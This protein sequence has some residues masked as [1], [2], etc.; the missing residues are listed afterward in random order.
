[1]ITDDTFANNSPYLQ[2]QIEITASCATGIT[3]SYETIP[4]ELPKYALHTAPN[5]AAWESALSTR[6]Q[7]ARS[8]SLWVT[9]VEAISSVWRQESVKDR[10]QCRSCTKC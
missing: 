10:L 7:L 9:F 4:A 5:L 6:N 3:W 1:M 2:K 8:I